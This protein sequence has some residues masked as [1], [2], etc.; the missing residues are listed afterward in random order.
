[1]SFTFLSPLAAL[2]IVGCGIP[3]AALAQVRAKGRRTRIAIGLPEPP[4]RWY[5]VSLTALMI[6][7]SFVGLAAGQPV[8]EFEQT[9]RVRTD[10]EV[11]IAIDTTRSMLARRNTHAPSRMV[12]AKAAALEMREA[13]PTVPVGIASMTDRTLPHL[14]PSADEESFRATLARSIG[15]ERP[16]PIS[17]LSRATRLESLAAVATQG[18]FS[19][20]ARHRVLVVFTDGESLPPTQ[21]HLAAAFA[22]PPGLR[23]VFIQFWSSHERVFVG[24]LPESGYRPDRT[25]RGTLDR[26]AAEVGGTVFSEHELPAAKQAVRGLLGTGP[27]VVRGQQREHIAL[28]PFLA[29]AAFFPLVLLLWRRD[30]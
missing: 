9:S 25:A 29:G 27:T 26:F 14:F 24:R 17:F 23:T 11:V 20:R 18:F 22:R 16:P 5:L 8:V 30:R 3:L 10:A 19:P 6:A 13:I 28:A 1:V 4:R 21:A 12:R 15:V 2:V 7:A